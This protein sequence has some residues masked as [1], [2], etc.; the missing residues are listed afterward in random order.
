MFGSSP[1]AVRS[2]KNSFTPL[3][4]SLHG[5]RNVQISNG[6]GASSSPT[7]TTS[8]VLGRAETAFASLAHSYSQL[9]DCMDHPDEH[10]VT[11]KEMVSIPSGNRS[12]LRNEMTRQIRSRIS[13]F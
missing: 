12:K 4:P 2:S 7:S 6:N 5:S 1:I 9:L 3:K 10:N 11:P 8:N 13:I